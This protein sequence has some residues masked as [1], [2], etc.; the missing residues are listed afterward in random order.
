MTRC[1][2]EGMPD[3]IFMKII[4]G[5]IPCYK[6]YEDDK[7][8]AFLDIHPVQPGHTLV[9]SKKQI[10]FIWD[11][12]EEE[13]RAV[14]DTAQK[15]ARR[16]QEVLK[17]PYVGEQIIGVDVPHAHIHII[18]FSTT[19]EFRNRPDMNAEPDHDALAEMANKLAF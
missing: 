1:Y 7:T 4:R 18:P 9:I 19:A 2:T 3:S 11:L 14:T 17:T 6:V 16:L 5:E 15:V 10:E 8:F 13:Y 12:D